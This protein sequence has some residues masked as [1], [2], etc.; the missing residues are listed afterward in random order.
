MANL[1]TKSH[2]VTDVMDNA[3]LTRTQANSAVD[4]VFKSMFE[5]LDAERQVR[6]P[7]IGTLSMK[8][9]NARDVRDPRTG[10]VSH[11]RAHKAVKFRRS[12]KCKQLLTK[13][14]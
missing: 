11:R 13:D 9:Q 14:V 4:A 12:S 6:L 5:A 3:G 2:F 7:N 1:H 8:L 10:A